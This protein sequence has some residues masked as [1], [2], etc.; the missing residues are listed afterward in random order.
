MK[1]TTDPIKFLCQFLLIAAFA[2]GACNLLTPSGEPQAT[3]VVAPEETS[4]P[5]MQ[6]TPVPTESVALPPTPSIPLSSAPVFAV[7]EEQTPKVVAVAGH[8]PIASDLSNV[9][10]P[11]VL[12]QAQLERLGRDGLVVSPGTE[13]EF[14]T[15]YEKSRYNNEPIFVT[16]DSL[17]HI[18]HLLFDKVLRT[19]ESEYFIPLLRQLNQALLAE[20][21]A[22][23]QAL[24]GSA[25]EDAALRTTAFVGVA[26]KLLDPGVQPP[27]YAAD[28]VSAELALIDAAEMQ[29]SPLFPGLEYGEDYT[30]YIPRGH[31]TKSEELKAYF[32]S[33]MWY[34]R[35]TFRLKGNNPEIGRAETRSAIL[36]VNALRNA[37]VN[38]APALKAWEDLYSPTVFFVG[39]SD[40]LTV[41]QYGDVIDAL[42][43][44]NPSPQTLADDAKLDP[45]IELANQLPP[46]RILGIVIADTDDVEETT[47]GLRFMGQRFVPDAYVFRQLIYR[48]VGTRENPRAL[49]KGLDLFAAMGSER[50]YQLL[51]EM[52]ETSYANYPEQMS[53]S[54]TWLGSVTAQEW[55]ETLNNAW[56]Y[57]FYPLIEVPGEGYPAFMRSTAWLDKQLNTSLGSWTELKHDTILYAKQV[58]AELGGG[59]PPPPPLPP[60]GYVEPV[61]H[62]Y[63]RLKALT[64]MTRHGLQDRGLLSDLDRQS[65]TKLEELT[66][67]FQVMAEKELRGEPLTDDEDTLIRFYGGDLEH[68]TMASSDIENY[69]PFGSGFMDEEPQAAVIAD[70]A[71][72]PSG[73]EGVQGPAVLEE[74]V[75]RVNPIF[76]VVP[77]VET[78]G[79]RYLQVAKGGV[80]SYY[81]FAWPASDRLT[82]EKWRQMLERGEAPAPPAWTA[83]FF[84]QEGEYSELTLAVLSFQ[85]QLTQA[86][87]EPQ[88]A[89]EFPIEALR[90]QIKA[91]VDQRQYIG[92]QLVS[93]QFRSFD[94]QSE[95]RAVVTVREAWQDK[96]FAGDYPDDSAEPLARRGPYSLD[97]TYTL[98]YVQTEYGASWQVVQFVYANQPPEWGN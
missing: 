37:Q 88:Y 34:G 70:V 12:S 64:A 46:P 24:R 9:R 94:L 1:Q 61:P 90:P 11:F 91:L 98:E 32:K 53:K 44:E 82:D 20:A 58:Y 33:M 7:F 22:Q 26:S 67:A 50:A 55:T 4:A 8:E 69:D 84:T 28:L 56:L 36:L 52:G 40:D 2:A 57:S 95:T 21:D 18:Y 45:F 29:K 60:R 35:M 14:F 30:Q 3:P 19:A 87:W 85:K 72:N 83:S 27:A 15:L 79:E 63:A 89:L 74:G 31:Y 17:L 59:P 77:I 93:S 76:V 68:L 10:V 62:F 75:G 39:R 86:Y 78:D 38:G 43:G 81:E 48:N 47:K 51:D 71:T 73:A 66:T 65:L 80:F 5:P 41:I 42:Y 25:W 49:P 23:Y 13:K 97:V 92:H 6:D 96:L 16:S 54:R